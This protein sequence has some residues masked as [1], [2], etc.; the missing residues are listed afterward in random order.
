MQGARQFK[1]H[2][3]PYS[4]KLRGNLDKHLRGKHKLSVDTQPELMRKVM[5]EGK[6]YK[7]YLERL[8]KLRVGET[9]PLPTP[10]SRTNIAGTGTLVQGGSETSEFQARYDG[11]ATSLTARTPYFS[12]PLTSDASEE[13]LDDACL[14]SMDNAQSSQETQ[15]I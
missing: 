11:I 12:V 4:C 15:N 10:C 13:S 6:G 7:E 1:C 14:E 3:C 8:W 9:I 2:L 5:Q